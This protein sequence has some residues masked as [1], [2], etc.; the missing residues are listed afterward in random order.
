LVRLEKEIKQFKEELSRL[1]WFMRGGVTLAEL[2]HTY[3]SDD[4]EAMY[5]VIKENL[6]ATKNSQMPLV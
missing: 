3:S 1:S 5:A 4:R 6:E 2:L